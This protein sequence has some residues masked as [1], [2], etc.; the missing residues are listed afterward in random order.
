MNEDLYDTGSAVVG[1]Y[2]LCYQLYEIPWESP[3]LGDPL[4]DVLGITGLS[5]TYPSFFTLLSIKTIRDPRSPAW[6]A[7]GVLYM[8]LGKKTFDNFECS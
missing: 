2:R 1:L 6:G 5:P 3:G 4:G 7:G 8:K